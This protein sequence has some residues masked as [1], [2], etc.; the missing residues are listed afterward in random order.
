MFEQRKTAVAV[1][2]AISIGLATSM[3]GMTAHAQTATTEKTVITGSNIKRVDAESSQPVTV[4]SREEI[5]RSGA[6]SVEQLLQT[7]SSAN[8]NGNLVASAASGATTGGISTASL[9]G[10]GSQRTLVLINGRRATA[11]GTITDSV[12]VDVNSIPLAAIDRIEILRDGASAI[13]GSDAIAG[14]VNFILR[15]DFQGVDATI[16]YGKAVPRGGAIEKRIS[17]VAGFGNVAKDR[18]NVMLVGNYSES[19]ALLGRDRDFANSGV[20]VGAGNDGTSGNTF[21]ANILLPDGRTRNP[22]QGNCAPSISDPLNNPLT[23]CR[24]DPAPYVTL[25]PE[26]KRGGLFATAKFAITS[27]LEAFVDASFNR[28]EQR[29]VIQP[30]PISDQFA[31]PPSHPLFNVAPYNGANTIV[32]KPSS[33]FYPAAY[34]RTLIGATA[35]L[36]EVLVRY[37]SFGTGPRDL[38]DKASVPRIVFGI[39]GALAGWDFDSSFMYTESKLTEHVNGGYPSLNKILPLL[40]SGQVNF[41]GP[42]TAAV[43]SQLDATQFVDDAYTTKSSIESF[44]AKGSR[45]LFALPAGPLAV[46]VGTELRKEKFVISPNA[47]IQTGDISGYGGNFLPVN[48]SRNVKAVFAE[49]N[50]PLVKNLEANAAVRFDDYEGVGSKTTPKV[51]LRW[52]PV[53]EV[54]VRGS[55]G[56]GF[57]APSLLDLYAPNLTGVT[58]AGI[59]DPLRCPTTGNSNDCQTQFSQITGG[60][61]KL[62]PETSD[63]FTL[64]FV[65]EPVQNFSMAVDGF[66]IKVKETIIYGLTPSTILGDLGQF[67]ALVTRGPVQAAFPKLP[68]PITSIDQTNLNLGETRVAGVDIDLRS[69]FPAGEAGRFAVRL[70]GTYFHQYDTQNLDGTFTNAISN[71][72]STTGSGGLVPRWKHYLSFDW[73]KGPWSALLAQNFQSAY[74]DLPSTI[75]EDPRRVGAYETFDAQG[76]WSGIKGFRFTLGVR[77][78][79]DR[80]PPYTNV[81]GQNYFQSGYD[82]SYASPIGRFIYG[83]VNYAF[84]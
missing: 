3:V 36:P 76:S 77:N 71:V 30:V 79:F 26:A 6:S 35:P 60:N 12:S 5:D 15:S 50:A 38:T 59:S 25:L 39:K 27:G 37:R 49:V 58:A 2:Q 63:N 53:K 28:S 20:N 69:V 41:F 23:R 57:R 7:I 1:W 44:S 80:A 9:R 17:G 66:K 74:N 51:G 43:Q 18:F 64:G 4:I 42:N 31:L 52:Q 73:T 78:I 14:V 22:F 81:G 19:D 61:S 32:L 8:N 21:P 65:F 40:N 33:P 62:K 47:T 54:L 67:G 56:K 46:A 75:S 55:F 68:G 84:K 13:Y 72:A 82:I 11:Y 48:R 34:I 70:N 45:E 10:L 16:E 29:F 24:F 83:R